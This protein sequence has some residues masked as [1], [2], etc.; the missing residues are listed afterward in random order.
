V[1]QPRIAA[2]ARLA[3]GGVGPKRVISGQKTRLGRTAH[4]IAYNPVRDEIVVPNPFAAAILTFRAD[5]SGD[6]APLRII[7]G[8]KTGLISPH[9]LGLDV[10]NK[11]LIVADVGARQVM[12]YPWDAE[13]DVAPIRVL[14]GSNAQ[15]AFVVGPSVDP[16]R[17]LLV[18]S[19]YTE[20]PKTG[21]GDGKILVFRRTDNGNVAPQRTIGGP[22]T[23]I[24]SPWQVQ[25]DPEAGKIFVAIENA[26][27][28][29]GR[30]YVEGKPQVGR[31][32]I[33]PSPWRSDMPGFIGVW[34]IDDHGDVPPRSII[35]GTLS[36]I[37]H[38]SGLYIDPKTGEVMAT[39]S[40]RNGVFTFYVPEFFRRS[41]MT[42]GRTR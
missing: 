9:S 41:Q 40:V 8:P 2:F 32:D 10:A 1:T 4:G 25:V 31:P 24:R 11:E 39:D 16:G 18:V 15:F 36:Q 34:D 33:P 27:R 42:D 19:T 28:Q 35:R 22:R 20:S 37:V 3:N 5:A 38:P 17:N 23:G 7:Q 14:G 26:Y 29:Y 21:T 13:G 12:V 6:V 30:F